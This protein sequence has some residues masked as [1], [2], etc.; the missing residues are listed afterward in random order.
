[1]LGVKTTC[2]DRWRQV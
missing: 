1:M 2:K